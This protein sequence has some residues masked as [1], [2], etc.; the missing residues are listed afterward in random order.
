MT[1]VDSLYRTPLELFLYKGQLGKVNFQND[2][3]FRQF[4]FAMAKVILYDIPTRGRSSCL[5][6]NVWKSKLPYALRKFPVAQLT[7]S[8]PA[9]S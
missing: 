2:K 3:A 5:S 7:Y 1:C 4:E 9:S 8:Q 6:H